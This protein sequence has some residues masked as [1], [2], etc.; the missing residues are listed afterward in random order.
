MRWEDVKFIDFDDFYQNRKLL[1]KFYKELSLNDKWCLKHFLY[2]E[3]KE[4]M[5]DKDVIWN[6]LNENYNCKKELAARV[7]T[8]IYSKSRRKKQQNI[9]EILDRIE[10]QKKMDLKRIDL[11]NMIDY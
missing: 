7:R 11:L 4:C 9:F 8:R 3:I 5:S 6:F 1:R 10:K 2:E